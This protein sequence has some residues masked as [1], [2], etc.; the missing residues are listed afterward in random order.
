MDASA[1][2][3]GVG[4]EDKGRLALAGVGAAVGAVSGA[5]ELATG[6]HH[7]SPGAAAAW[8][9]GGEGGTACTQAEAG[10]NGDH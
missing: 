10:T 2:A 4:H 6:V 5:R 8:V 7:S 1:G 3:V 9:D